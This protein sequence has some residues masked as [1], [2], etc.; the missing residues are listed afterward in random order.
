MRD[1]PDD[2]VKA[3]AGP[4]V[5][6]EAWQTALTESGIESRVVGE[7][8]SGSFGSALPGSMELWVHRDDLAAAQVVIRSVEATAQHGPGGP[9]SESE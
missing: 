9:D 4:V 7:D 2:V 8:L 3:A 5:Q 1:N 6:I